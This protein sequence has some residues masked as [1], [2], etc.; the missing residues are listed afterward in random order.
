MD[1]AVQ[2]SQIDPQR[3]LAGLSL[4]KINLLKPGRRSSRRLRGAFSG[5][6]IVTAASDL[7][8]VVGRNYVCS[9]MLAL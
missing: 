9:F 7:W 3:F 6:S 4:T 5:S 8:L 2:R 1:S